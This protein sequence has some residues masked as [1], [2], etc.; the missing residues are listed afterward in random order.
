MRRSSYNDIPAR[1]KPWL[2][3][4]RKTLLMLKDLDPRRIALVLIDLQNWT[5]GMPV[6]PHPSSAVIDCGSRLA[7]CLQEAGG[8]IILT[9]AAFSKGYVDA[10]KQPVDVA[11]PLP[12]G[13]LPP[14]ALAFS[15]DFDVKPDVVITKRQWSAFYGTELD[16]QLRRRG[17]TTVI[18]GGVMTN[19]GV[20]S[21][22]RDAWQQGYSVIVAEDASSSINADMHHFSIEKI[23]PRVSQ[24]RATA[25]I[26]ASLK[27]PVT[28]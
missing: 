28:A 7:Q 11:L 12:D 13:G 21:T 24:V 15:S 22:A 9:R 2:F 6:A 14:E 8:T 18:L 1:T 3:R 17:I 4:L 10:L 20:E 19:F 26:L 27:A 23:L 25:D 5:L 16:L